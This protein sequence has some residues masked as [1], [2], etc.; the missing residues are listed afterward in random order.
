MATP[1]NRKEIE[2]CKSPRL[3][4][5]AC[6]SGITRVPNAYSKAAVM[7]VQIP[8][9][10]SSTTRHPRLNSEKSLPARWRSRVSVVMHFHSRSRR[11]ALLALEDFFDLGQGHHGGATVHQQRGA[12]DVRRLVGGKEKHRIGYVGSLAQTP[13]RKLRRQLVGQLLAQG[14]EHVISANKAGL[15]YVNQNVHG[16]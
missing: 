5:K 10:P 12:G 13:D 11:V 6:S 3:Q 1:A 8:S 4:P 14:F 2:A 9:S 16:A 7:L 15:D